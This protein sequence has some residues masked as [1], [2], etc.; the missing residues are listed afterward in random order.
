LPPATQTVERNEKISGLSKKVLSIRFATREPSILVGFRVLPEAEYRENQLSGQS[1][2]KRYKILKFLDSVRRGG[3]CREVK[4]VILREL[5]TEE[6]LF[7][8]ENETLRFAQ[9]D[10]NKNL[11]QPAR[12][13]R[14]NDTIKVM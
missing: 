9:S 8:I 4:V 13:I 5:A 3:C 14:R 11:Q 2:R 1:P 6:S 7:L 12:R 10:K